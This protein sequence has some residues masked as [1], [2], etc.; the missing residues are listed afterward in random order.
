M[1]S[2]RAHAD[3]LALDYS[4]FT[5]QRRWTESALRE[6]VAAAG[7]WSDVVTTLGLRGGSAVASVKGHAAR[8]RLD[9]THLAVQAIETA[10][11]GLRPAL[12]CLGSA[13]SMMAAAW[14][15]LCG[16]GVA[17]PLEPARYDLLV[18]KGKRI[19][20]VQV[21]TTTVA[22]GKAGWKVQ[23]SVSRKECKTYD[24]DEIDDFFIIDG[25]FNYYLIPVEAVGGLYAIHVNAY[26]R[27]RVSQLAV[28]TAA[29]DHAA[30]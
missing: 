27:Y 29:I 6:A 23:L 10:P 14:F 21:K 9:T 24:P 12:D 13:G 18:T 20:R 7:S 4:H 2:I 30:S 1:R 19:R 5:G 16:C 17:W 15:K 22:A 3:R 28:G 8:L 11:H 25:D 26:A